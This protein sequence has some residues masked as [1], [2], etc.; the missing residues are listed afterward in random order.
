MVTLTVDGIVERSVVEYSM[1]LTVVGVGENSI[2]LRLA[3]TET[4]SMVVEET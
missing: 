1:T 4:L 3:I 2:T